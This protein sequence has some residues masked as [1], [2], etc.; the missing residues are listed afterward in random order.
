MIS[1]ILDCQKSWLDA[2]FKKKAAI[3]RM[4]ANNYNSVDSP[5]ISQKNGS[6]ENKFHKKKL[7][8]LVALCLFAALMV[9]LHASEEDIPSKH[10]FLTEKFSVVAISPLKMFAGSC[11]NA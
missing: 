3:F 4:S 5:F 11:V 6:R 9:D 10:F 2:S 7:F 8:L 1:R